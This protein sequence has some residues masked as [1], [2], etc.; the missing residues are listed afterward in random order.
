VFLKNN[1]DGSGFDLEALV[2]DLDGT[3]IDSIEVYYT[4][5]KTVFER[6]CWPDVPRDVMR[7][8]IKNDGFEWGFML[9]P[10]SGR[11]DE[12]LIAEA[13]EVIREVYPHLFEDTVHMVPGADQLLRELHEH[14]VKLGLVTSTLARF[15]EFKLIPL[16]KCGVRDL[17]HTVITLDDV[18]NRKPSG[19]PLLECARRIGEDPGKCAYVGDTTGDMVAGKAAG[20][21]TI[22]VLTG[23]HDYEA[24]K[25]E[26]PDLIVQSVSELPERLSL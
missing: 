3:L 17:F 18:E 9:P 16:K 23:L 22:G 19:D 7:K 11:S 15:I 14:R 24:L 1:N 4:M 20:M 21:R 10:G 6:L 12:A 2:F 5:M 25:A 13:R 8:A 26:G